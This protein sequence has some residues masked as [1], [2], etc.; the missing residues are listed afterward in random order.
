MMRYSE[1]LAL[2]RKFKSHAPVD[3]EG[4]ANALGVKVSYANLRPET[5]GMIERIGD[6]RFRIVVNANH[7]RTRQRFTIAHEL[8]HYML[9]RH[10]IGEGIEDNRAYRSSCDGVYRNREIGPSQE[11]EANKFAVS[12]LMPEHLMAEIRNNPNYNIPA[13]KARALGVC[14]HAYCIREGLDY[15]P[16]Y[17]R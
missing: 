7:P 15:E 1:Q 14:E 8:G 16:K 17:A 11:T 9:H 5:S 12:V 10:L 2:I 6:D 4:L 13:A 3:V